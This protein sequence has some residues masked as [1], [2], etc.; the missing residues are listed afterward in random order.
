[1]MPSKISLPAFMT[2]TRSVI[3]SMKPMRCSTTRRAMPLRASSLRRSAT[4]ASLPRV[5][6]ASTSSQVTKRPSAPEPLGA[7][8]PTIAPAYR[9]KLMPS[10]ARKRPKRLTRLSTARSGERG[11]SGDIEPPTAQQRDQS[12]RQEQ[13]QPHDEEAVD[14]LEILRRRDADGVVNAVE[15]D[16]AEQRPDDGR[17]A[18]EQREDDG[19]DADLA[20]EHRLRLEDRNVPSEGAG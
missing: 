11:G 4:Q 18:A 19:E 8:R 2:M 13:H 6:T 12:G 17:R 7:T 15:D 14:E 16:D 1:M 9:S 10:A 20:Q 3:W 5:S